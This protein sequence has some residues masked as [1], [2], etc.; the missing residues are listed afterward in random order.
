ML[1]KIIK[2]F[3]GSDEGRPAQQRPILDEGNVV[4]TDANMMIIAPAKYFEGKYEWD[5]KFPD[6]KSCIPAHEKENSLFVIN[7]A[8]VIDYVK[9]AETE[10]VYADC[11]KCEGTGDEMCDSCG[12]THDCD[13]CRGT[14]KGSF[15]AREMLNHRYS[16]KINDVCLSLKLLYK[17]CLVSELIGK[18]PVFC[19]LQKQK[20]CVCYVNDIEILIMPLS[21]PYENEMI[22]TPA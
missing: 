4:A 21:E 13:Q 7:N 20:A 1:D 18:P 9:G 22:L 17:I 16:V 11:T 8:Q 5:D 6:Y 12:H 14:G 2:S 15:I 3:C 19:L 10:P